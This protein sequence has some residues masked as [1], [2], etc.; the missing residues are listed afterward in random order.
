MKEKIVVIGGGISGLTAAHKLSKDG[1]QVTLIESSDRLGGL[2]TYFNYNG[3]WVDKFYHCQ[4]P[5]DAP[6]LDLIEQV[7]LSGQLYWKNTRMGFIVDGKRYAFNGA[8]DLLKFSPLKFFQRIR[9]GIA[10]LMIRHL[11]KGI[12]LDNTRI[13]D[14]FIKLYG[15]DVWEK[16]LQPLF[17]SKF[18][19]HAGNLPALYIWER[20]GREKN[21]AK[22]GYLKTGL[23]GLI[24]SLEEK[25]RSYNGKILLNT[26]VIKID[27]VNDKMT[28]R[29]DNNELLE[30]D[31]VI[32]TAP[33]SILANM[34]EDSSL[35]KDFNNPNLTYQGVVNALFFLKKPLDN[36][37]WQPV[38][39]SNT[40][41][42]GV[43][44]MSE[45]VNIEQYNNRYL[46]YVMKYCSKD[47]ELFKEE[48]GNIALRWKE[49]LK[50]LFKDIPLTDDDITDVK[51]FKAP[52]VEPVYPLGYS[53]IKP[54]IRVGNSKLLL[55][56]SAQVYPT[57]TSWNSSVRLANNV[58]DNLKNLIANGKNE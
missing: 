14:W 28:L 37:Y 11:G 15:K 10:S 24:D 50:T 18:G 20:L 33:I 40:E 2:G 45:L 32:S 8:L 21:T 53:K 35:D 1:F 58:V 54:E 56:S 16:I 57:I 46:V 44:E 34:L 5:S 48:A 23:K 55:A 31:W 9:F 22:R 12:D 42:D 39:N 41:F 4:M 19:S 7:G 30:C 43:V 26:R 6:L 36:F 38:V 3:K 47:S 52:Y 49:Q 27:Q 29:L 17:R 25:I 51:I 13:E